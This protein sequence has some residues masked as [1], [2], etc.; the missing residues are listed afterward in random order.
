MDLNCFMTVFNEIV[1]K[2]VDDPRKKLTGLIMYTTGD[3][4]ETVKS[5]IQWL[6]EIGF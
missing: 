5:C 3:A 6:A 1:E 2:K 4:K